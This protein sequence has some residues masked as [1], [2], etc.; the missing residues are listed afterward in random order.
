MNYLGA[1][2]FALDLGK[3][4]SVSGDNK[5]AGVAAIAA[6]GIGA[7]GYGA[8]SLKH[9][10]KAKKKAAK[11]KEESKAAKTEEETTENPEQCEEDD[12][13]VVIEAE[14]VAEEEA[15]LME[16]AI[17]DDSFEKWITYIEHLGIADLKE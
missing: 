12:E 4:G 9:A 17:S 8:S 6:L 3:L 7:I 16:H 10:A 5:I 1:M 14:D 13:K 15:C 11:D 2:R